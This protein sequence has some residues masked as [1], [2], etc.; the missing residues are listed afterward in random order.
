MG[1]P[2]QNS[3][4]T[5]GLAAELRNP[6]MFSEGARRRLPSLKHANTYNSSALKSSPP[7]YERDGEDTDRRRRTPILHMQ[8]DELAT[9]QLHATYA[10]KFFRQ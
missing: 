2:F 10:N 6:D 7:A 9:T 5:I 1:N 4:A 8:F 3:G